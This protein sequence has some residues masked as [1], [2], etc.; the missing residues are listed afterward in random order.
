[1]TFDLVLRGER[2][3]EGEIK[4]QSSHPLSSPS[5]STST[6]PLRPLPFKPLYYC[7][8]RNIIISFHL[9]ITSAANQLCRPSHAPPAVP[10]SL[11]LPGSPLQSLTYDDAFFILPRPSHGPSSV[12]HPYG[13]IPRRLP[14]SRVRG[15]RTIYIVVAIPSACGPSAITMARPTPLPRPHPV[16]LASVPFWPE[17]QRII[18]SII[19]PHHLYTEETGLSQVHSLYTYTDARVISLG[20]S[21]ALVPGRVRSR[22]TPRSREDAARQ[23]SS[24]CYGNLT[25]PAPG[26]REKARRLSISPRALVAIS[27]SGAVPECC[28]TPWTL[29]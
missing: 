4:R 29:R 7:T 19:I 25:T 9:P 23:K 12:F 21:H 16:R 8:P 1:V 20:S 10:R 2:H 14:S 22:I 6:S 26:R 28:P 15:A 17:V 5:T 11:G 3:G 18:S 27:V 13:A 24:Q